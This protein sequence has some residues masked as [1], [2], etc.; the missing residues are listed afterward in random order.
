MLKS[1]RY[2][3]RRTVVFCLT[4]ADSV[5]RRFTRH[6]I[7]IDGNF[8]Q[9]RLK[10]YLFQFFRHRINLRSDKMFIL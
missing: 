8:L 4:N 2:F 7:F 9:I 1:L 5:N 3:Q 10:Y 6:N